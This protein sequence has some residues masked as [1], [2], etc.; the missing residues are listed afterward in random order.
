MVCSIAHVSCY[1]IPSRFRWVELSLNILSNS[2]KL[3]LAEDVRSCIGNIPP[4]LASQYAIIYDEIMSSRHYTS[5]LA[6]HFFVWLLAAQRTMTTSEHIAAIALDENRTWHDGICSETIL[7]ICR[8]LVREIPLADS[9]SETTFQVAHLSVKE[10]LESLAEMTPL[11]I[12]HIALSR[13][14]REYE[15]NVIA[16]SGE[17]QGNFKQYTKYLCEHGRKSDLVQEVSILATEALSFFWDNDFHESAAY[18]EWQDLFAQHANC[19]D[20]FIST[21]D[22]NL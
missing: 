15:P 5:N 21:S 14:L 6:R 8:N 2:R 10:F 4:E 3:G 17:Y 16:N 22:D 20:N 1:S 9:T 11:Q 13:C 12:H 18:L 19:R 7:D